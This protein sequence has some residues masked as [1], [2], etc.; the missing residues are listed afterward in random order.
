MKLGAHQYWGETERQ[1]DLGGLSV[2]LTRYPAFQSQARHSHENP[3]YFFLLGGDFTDVSSER[4]ALAPQRFE[5]LFH[6]SGAPHEGCSGP[7][8]RFGLNFEPSESWLAK[9]DLKASDLGSY[10]IDS[11]P[12]RAGELLRL[13]VCGFEAVQ[14]ESQLLE[15]L[16]PDAL[17]S[18]ESPAW[19]R[20]V[21]GLLDSGRPWSLHSLADE[22][23]VHPV[24]LARVF[25]ARFGVSVSEWLRRRRLVSCARSLMDGRP[26]SEVAHEEGFADQSHFGRAFRAYFDCTPH[27]FQ[28][29]WA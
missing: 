21:R 19:F 17:E 12:M 3:T 25:R 27:E 22:L 14:A 10:R 2:S 11:D 6:P 29:R 15:I 5:L 28:R 26:S 23:A 20:K 24:Y 4:G 8:G 7:K 13:N 1:W 18:Q 16:L 9:N